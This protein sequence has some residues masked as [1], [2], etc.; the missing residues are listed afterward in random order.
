M[1]IYKS[2][3]LSLALCLCFSLPLL[4]SHSASQGNTFVSSRMLQEVGFTAARVHL[5]HR[6]A[7]LV[8]ILE[9]TAH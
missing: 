4:L 6:R 3:L 1:L 5:G 8:Y 9:I 2:L 7:V